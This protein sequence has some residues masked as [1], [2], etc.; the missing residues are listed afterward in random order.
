MI[1]GTAGHIDHG[2]SALVSALTGKPMD[3]LLEE[4]R[5]EITIELNFAPLDLGSGR[6]AGVVDVPGHEDFV[7]TM[8]AGASGIDLVLLVIAADEGIMPQ[9]EEHLAIL[10]QLGVAGGIPVITKADLVDSEW[11]ELVTSDVAERLAVSPIDFEPPLAVSARNGGGIEALRERLVARASLLPPRLSGDGFR[12]PIDRSF[13]LSGV[14][15]VVTGTAWSGRLGV[16]DPV[17]VLPAG[18]RARVRSIE[19]YGHEVERSDPRARTAVGLAGVE[20]RAVT[21]GDVLVTDELPWV[22]A[23][24][25][26]VQITLLPGAARPLKSRT[27]VRL[28]LGTTEVMAR[29]LPRLPIEPGGT[30]MA[31]LTLE[32]SLV[33]RA[34]DRF[35]LR[36]YSPVTTIG[37]GRVL[38]PFPPG[39]RSAWPEGLAS[40]DPA[41]RFRAALIRRRE[42]IQAA[43][44][45]LLLG[46]PRAAAAEVARAETTA[47]L[48]GEIWVRG[49]V[50]KEVGLRALGVLRD[51]HRHHGSDAGMPLETLRHSLVARDVVVEA[52]LSDFA[53]AGRLRRIDGVVALAGFV[54]QVVG[55]DSAID[56]VV[57]LLL[58]ANLN[59]PSIPELE[60]S[61]GRRD[62]LAVLRLAAA[63]GQVEAVER[64]RYYAREALD[65]FTTVLNDLGRQGEIVPGAVRERL[66]LTRKYL[67]PL[68]EWADGKGITVR[69]GEG[70]RLKRVGSQESGA[71][72]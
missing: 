67:I 6:T 27:R 23:S 29:V 61:T 71:R 20:R 55:G 9:T 47:R 53:Q 14:G 10:E 3:R 18:L 38:D 44:L 58:E 8:V 59:P 49:E 60:R 39:R 30:G 51:Y 11:L 13:S 2:K 12:M 64:D 69:V 36:S 50:V 54:P 42:G 41:E 56:G 57:R 25:L 48:L 52:A 43:V 19:S 5:R 40:L 16:G 22:A 34:E 26:D 72:S 32:K 68:L 70:R 4:R 31:R 7:R 66:G 65:Q 15:T 35:V 33:A 28:H 46:L 17:S 62:L 45:P 21:R 24:A 37:G 63:R 1:I